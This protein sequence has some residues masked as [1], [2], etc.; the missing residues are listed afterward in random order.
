M[1]TL[2]GSHGEGGGALL[3]TAVILASLTE[4]PVRIESIRGGTAHPGLDVE[5]LTIVQA[6]ADTTKA[7]VAGAEL[8]SSQLAFLPT[9][10][11]TGLKRSVDLDASDGVRQPNALVVLSS[12][13]PVLARSGVY[14][15]VAATGET[16]GANAL[17]YDYFSEVACA[18]LRRLGIGAFP[19]QL[20]AG[21]GRLA[22][23]RIA[24]DIEP[25]AISG[26]NWSDRG[27][28]LE[29]HVRVV[30][31]N[32]PAQVGARGT[33]HASNIAKTMGTPFELE[34][35]ELDASGPGAF[36][37]GWQVY[38]RGLF[39]ATA[40]GTRGVRIEGLVQKVFDGLIDWTAGDATIDPYLAD[41]LIVPACLADEPT[42][43]KL[44]TLSR[45]LLTEIWVIKQFLP[46][47]VTVKGSEG[48]PGTITVRKS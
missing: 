32:L 8:G 34:A 18:G 27:K 16:Y 48:K 28:L 43:L 17:S 23:G 15:Q 42:V 46:I 35:V 4:Q 37:T 29:S 14:S 22:K 44:P 39:G 1:I 24:L 21:Y 6:L 25:S 41:Q 9:R 33:A 11:A 19:D 26:L 20:S 45:R 3:R 7:E 10:R 30:T 12:L 36:V 47:H 38:E 2:D 5:D 40:M 13:I 31:S